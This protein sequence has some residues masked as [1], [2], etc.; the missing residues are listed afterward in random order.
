MNSLL[1][2]CLQVGSEDALSSVDDLNVTEQLSIK[3]HSLEQ[4]ICTY[5]GVAIHWLFYIHIFF[6]H[7]HLT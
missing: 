5:Y 1:I 7:R 6:E 4:V 3:A 2:E